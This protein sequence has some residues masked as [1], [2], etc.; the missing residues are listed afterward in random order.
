[1]VDVSTWAPLASIAAPYSTDGLAIRDPARS[2]TTPAVAQVLAY[3]GAVARSLGGRLF[4]AD[5]SRADRGAAFPP[6]VSHRLGIDVDVSYVI[7]PPASQANKFGTPLTTPVEPSWVQVLCALR[8][9]VDRVGVSLVRRQQIQALA[10]LQK[11]TPPKLSVWAGHGSHAHIRF[12]GSLAGL[13]GADL[14]PDDDGDS[15]AQDFFLPDVGD[16]A[17]WSGPAEGYPFVRQV[18][19]QYIS[20][21]E[22][23][24]RA[25]A[26]GQPSTAS[27]VLGQR[28]Y[29]WFRYYHAPDWG[30]TDAECHAPGSPGCNFYR[31]AVAYFVA[32]ETE[33]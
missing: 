27:L 15:F 7:S 32:H 13:G 5:V 25:V 33:D 23:L 9:Y 8:P 31:A 22:Q 18:L 24:G 29:D 11:C 20:T 21:P 16:D 2:Y 12:L 28:A 6:H 19:E 30:P 26:P 10:T 3:A 1:M 4:V 17:G 14:Q